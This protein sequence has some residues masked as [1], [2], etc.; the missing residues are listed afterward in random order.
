MYRF[1]LIVAQT[2]EPMF[3]YKI[4]SESALNEQQF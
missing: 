4:F 2:F 3:L 1:N